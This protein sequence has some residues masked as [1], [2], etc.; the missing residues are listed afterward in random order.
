MANHKRTLPPEIQEL[1]DRVRTYRIN[2]SFFVPGVTRGDLEFLRQ[3]CLRQGTPISIHYVAR[4]EKHGQA[5]VRVFR[6][7]GEYD[8]L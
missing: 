2:E 1:L 4:D 7:E 3:P 6:K 5:G 8:N